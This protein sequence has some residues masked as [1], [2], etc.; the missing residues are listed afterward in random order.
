MSHCPRQI[1]FTIGSIVNM[2]SFH[3]V[4]NSLWHACRATCRKLPRQEKSLWHI[5]KTPNSLSLIL[6]FLFSCS[7]CNSPEWLRMIYHWEQHGA[8]LGML[9][10][11][12]V[13]FMLETRGL[14]ATHKTAHSFVLLSPFWLKTPFYTSNITSRMDV[15]EN[16]GTRLIW[17]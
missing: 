17:M 3:A 6:S 15:T 1:S 16:E 11:G 5:L 10:S 4:M 13:C 2:L 7:F 9:W 14:P 12:R 8:A